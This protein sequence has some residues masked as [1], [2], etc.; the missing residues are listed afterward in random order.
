MRVAGLEV[1]FDLSPCCGGFATGESARLV[2]KYRPRVPVLL[3]TDSAAAARSCA[4]CFGVHVNLVQKLPES[5]FD[6]SVARLSCCEQPGTP[7]LTFARCLS[8]YGNHT[9]DC[10][11]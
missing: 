4:P 11:A 5:R 2:S 9:R 3:V 10:A 8:L 1:D 7:A 6:V